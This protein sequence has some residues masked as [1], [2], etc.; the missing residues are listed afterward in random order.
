MQTDQV[1]ICSKI[2][3]FKNLSNDILGS[4]KA[5]SCPSWYIEQCICQDYISYIAGRDCLAVHII[6]VSFKHARG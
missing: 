2:L 4:K 1:Y 5:P 6:R 3:I